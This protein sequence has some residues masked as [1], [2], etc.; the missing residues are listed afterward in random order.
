LPYALGLHTA[1]SDLALG[2]TNFDSDERYASWPLGRDLSVYLQEYLQKFLQPQTWQD[3]GSIA[4]IC[5]PGSFTGT[6]MGVVTAR[7]LAQQLNLPLFPVSTLLAAAWAGI[8]SQETRGV[9]AIIV[10]LPAQQGHVYGAVYQVNYQPNSTSPG[11]QPVLLKP[12][13]PEQVFRLSD[14]QQTL[15]QYGFESK[16]DLPEKVQQEKFLYL[17]S[18]TLFP[19]ASAVCRA[20]LELVEQRWQQGE[21][22]YWSATLPFYG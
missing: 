11:S 14:W 21:R 20:M 1:S 7:T 9:E 18:S 17:G 8:S 4:V 12:I 6:R 3:L 13:V 10:E 19:T 5:G 15:E 16:A 22:P 2:I